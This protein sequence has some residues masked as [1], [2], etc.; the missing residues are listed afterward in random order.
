MLWRITNIVLDLTK[1][2]MLRPV[3]MPLDNFKD[4]FRMP[5]MIYVIG[6]CG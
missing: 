3:A 2:V 1:I 5:F 6:G 4:G